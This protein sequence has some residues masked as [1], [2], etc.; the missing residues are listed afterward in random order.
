MARHHS[1]SRGPASQDVE[2]TVTA[3]SA[4][5]HPAL[6]REQPNHLTDLHATTLP[7]VG[8]IHRPLMTS[9]QDR[10]GSRGSGETAAARGELT[11]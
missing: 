5:E 4:D 8:F 10:I 2:L 6:S 11:S 9:F 3:L 1:R 7:V